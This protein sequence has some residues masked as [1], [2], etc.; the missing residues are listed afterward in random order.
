MIATNITDSD[1]T[2]W[3]LNTF[4]KKYRTERIKNGALAL[5]F[6][7]ATTIEMPQSKTKKIVLPMGHTYHRKPFTTMLTLTG[8]VGQEIRKYRAT[9]WMKVKGSPDYGGLHFFSNEE[10]KGSL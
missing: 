9:I 2:N 7:P 8:T 5:G 3:D 1:T 10:Q 6:N 4:W